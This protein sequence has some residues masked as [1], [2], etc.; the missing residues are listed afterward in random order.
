CHHRADWV[1]RRAVDR[2]S[3]VGALLAVLPP[4]RLGSIP[5]FALPA[6]S[7][8]EGARLDRRLNATRMHCGSPSA[9]A[10]PSS[11]PLGRTASSS[12][13][14]NCNRLTS[15]VLSPKGKRTSSSS[16]SPSSSLSRLLPRSSSVVWGH[17]YHSYVTPSLEA[18][19]ASRESWAGR[20][21]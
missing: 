10:A 2:Q 11:S 20:T 8:L 21:A 18:D 19:P 6:P 7:Q 4:R 5:R 14:P 13:S 15:L 9:A 3:V 12:R 1:L 17:P 16:S